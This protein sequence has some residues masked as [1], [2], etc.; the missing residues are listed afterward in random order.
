MEKG[1]TALSH[2]GN[3]T[4]AD[5]QL[6]LQSLLPDFVIGAQAMTG[7]TTLDQ[8]LGAVSSGSACT[9]PEASH[10]RQVRAH[11][12]FASENEKESSLLAPLSCISNLFC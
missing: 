12:A 2:C 4:C 7:G 3:L 10:G 5:G 9:A 1:D 11:A 6:T 8:L